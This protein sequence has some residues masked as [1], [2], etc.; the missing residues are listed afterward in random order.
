MNDPPLWWFGSPDFFQTPV[1]VSSTDAIT[2]DDLKLIGQLSS[3]RVVRLRGQNITDA[4]LQHL[5]SLHSLVEFDVT[6]DNLTDRG[7]V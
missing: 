7:L 1:S 5:R 3:L 2:H 6:S 4:G